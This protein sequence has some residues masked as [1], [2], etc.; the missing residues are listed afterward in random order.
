MSGGGTARTARA[1]GAVSAGA[2]GSTPTVLCVV[3]HSETGG[4]ARGA[5]T[6]RRVRRSARRASARAG[7]SGRRASRAQAAGRVVEEEATDLPVVV[8]GPH[9]RQRPFDTDG[10]KAEAEPAAATVKN[11]AATFIFLLLYSSKRESDVAT[12]ASKAKVPQ[13]SAMRGMFGRC[14]LVYTYCFSVLGSRFSVL[15]SRADLL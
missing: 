11:E 8:A 4:A 10:A 5:S 7:M 6:R 3:R 1:R 12:P 13:A 15:S 9:A 14:V 2:A